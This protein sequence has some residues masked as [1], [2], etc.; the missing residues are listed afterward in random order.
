MKLETIN[1][2]TC[3]SKIKALR[4]VYLDEKLEKCLYN[5]QTK[6]CEQ[7]TEY[8]PCNRFYVRIKGIKEYYGK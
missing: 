7:C 5:C 6:D 2:N 3:I 8:I 4:S 1:G